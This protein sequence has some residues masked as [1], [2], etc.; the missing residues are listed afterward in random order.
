MSP[1]LPRGFGGPEEN[2]KAAR[3]G[4]LLLLLSIDSFCLQHPSLLQP[5][6]LA[7]DAAISSCRALDIRGGS[8]RGGGALL[9][10]AIRRCMQTTTR[11]AP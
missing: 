4:M 11:P 5:G 8:R 6:R 7:G 3:R 9:S 10:S 2:K 1:P